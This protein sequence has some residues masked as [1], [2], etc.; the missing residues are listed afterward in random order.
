M[1][2]ILNFESFGAQMKKNSSLPFA[3]HRNVKGGF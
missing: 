3:H 1:L 2:A